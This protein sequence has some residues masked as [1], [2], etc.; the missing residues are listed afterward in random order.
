MFY[1]L[2]T[3]ILIGLSVFIST[4]FFVTKKSS[5][6]RRIKNIELCREEEEKLNSNKNLSDKLLALLIREREQNLL[7]EVPSEKEQVKS[8]D[9][10][11][12]ISPIILSIFSCLVICSIYFQPFS[13]GNLNELRTHNT[14]YSFLEGNKEERNKKRHSLIIELEDLINSELSTASQ[15]YY[16]SIKFREI[17]EFLFSSLLL[18]GLIN[19]YKEEIPTY[20]YSEYAQT[21]FFK[22]GR[23]FSTAVNNALDDALAK[24]PTNAIALTLK[25]IKH[26]EAGDISLAKLSWTE[27]IKYTN[28]ETEKR[29]IQDAIDSIKS[30]KNQ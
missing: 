28:S 25:G 24:S 15:L 8:I 21:L 29:S 4:T 16:L 11:I 10:N 13:L 23:T 7:Q 18:S 2:G 12:F 17:D 30:T 19:E 5:Y 3:A 22:E 20:I 6:D 9:R 1:I 26:F 14:I 27:A